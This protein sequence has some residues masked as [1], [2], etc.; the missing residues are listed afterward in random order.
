MQVSGGG[1]AST[2]SALFQSEGMASFWKG[3]TFAYGREIS[4]TS[5]K[6]GAYAPVRDFMGA[7]GP[8]ASLGLKFLAGAITG[9]V[10]SALGNPFDV[11]K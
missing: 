6:L 8:D 9:G 1:I 11:L 2:A 5:V 10:G 7:G 4:Y 3:L